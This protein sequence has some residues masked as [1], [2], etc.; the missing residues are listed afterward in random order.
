[1]S[2]STIPYGTQW[3]RDLVPGVSWDD[4]TKSVVLPDGKKI[5]KTGY[6][7]V[8]NKAYVSPDSV[9][10][11]M[12]QPPVTTPE[13]M[14]PD[15]FQSYYDKY[16][17]MYQPVLDSQTERLNNLITVLQDKLTANIDSIN[18]Q[19]DLSQHRLQTQETADSE[20]LR[21]QSIARGTYT[22]GVADYQQG[23]LAGDYAPEYADL[24]SSIAAMIGS[25]NVDANA[26][27]QSIG[28]QK[29]ELENNFTTNLMSFMN[30]MMAQDE[31][32]QQQAWQNS[33]DIKLNESTINQAALSEALSRTQM[34]GKVVTA[35]D[36]EILGVPIGTL[37]ADAQAATRASY[38]GGGGINTGG[39]DTDTLNL[40]GMDIDTQRAVNAAMEIWQVTGKAPAGI[41]QTL[42]GIEVGTPFDPALAEN[43]SAATEW[44]TKIK[45]KVPN[46]RDV[47]MN[48]A[49]N[50]LVIANGTAS[51]AIAAVNADKNNI[52]SQ[53]G[54]V[55]NIIAAINAVG[56][57]PPADTSNTYGDPYNNPIV[58]GSWPFAPGTPLNAP[59]LNKPP[60]NKPPLNLFNPFS[61]LM[62]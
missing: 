50:A 13:T 11:Y 12:T 1:M 31:A 48:F 2:E 25:A 36:A 44:A 33:Q 10:K 53:G 9:S 14:S 6:T 58:K 61:N 37:S 62:K 55:T 32:S 41:L 27:L 4:T 16:T 19:G 20:K 24:A 28:E 42:Y 23:Q 43:A 22:S 49:S 56:Y 60:L 51:A 18:A 15:K 52:K 46:I 7:I 35:K 57:I 26:N 47:D 21:N 54:N 39:G 34:F 59:V 5:D 8:N 30:S 45:S 38:G 3:I 40:D 17:G 29:T